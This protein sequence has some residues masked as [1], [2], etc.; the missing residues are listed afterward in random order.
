MGGDL[1]KKWNGWLR[2]GM[3]GLAGRWE[4]KQGDGLLGR[5]MGG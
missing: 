5:G 4:A 1:A 2:R 3:G